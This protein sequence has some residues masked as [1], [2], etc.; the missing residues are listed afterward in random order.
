M[1]LAL[2]TSLVVGLAAAAGSA[3]ANVY[4]N[5]PVAI[6]QGGGALI[7]DTVYVGLGSAGD[8]FFALDLKNANK[9]WT[10]LAT[11][12]GGSLSQ[13]VVAAVD[14]KIYVL[15]GVGTVNGLVTSTNDAYEYDPST[16]K[17]TKLATRSP[18]GLVGGTGFVY[19]DRIYV[20]GGTNLEIFNGFFKDNAAAKT[21]AEKGAVAA[22]YF[23]KRTQDYFFN[24]I[25]FSYQPSTNKWYNDGHLD[26][27]GR[28]GA[29]VA[30]K[31]NEFIVVNGE[32]K[33]GL[34]TDKVNL[35]IIGSDGEVKYKELRDLPPNPGEK[36]QDGVAG[37]YT[38]YIGKYLFVAGGA[39]FPGAHEAYEK[40]NLH[41]HKG[42]AKIY[43]K[44][45]FIYADGKWSYAGD[46]PVGSG[47][48]VALS[49]GN[50]LLI[51]GGE[52]DEGKPL[53]EVY[54]VTYDP[55]T[56]RVTFK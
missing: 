15:G 30:I 51:F 26:F 6:K 29:G 9:G 1:K 28:A 37:A 44:A 24:T 33:P 20:V 35:G 34:R 50:D 17:W 56:K 36:V 39:N 46:L 22:H 53:A 42:L 55:A 4:P 5:L 54:V 10:E 21:D 7:N 14:G 23:D 48:G 11:F 32:I 31:G 16:N 3:F 8:K 47:Y 45:A 25:L 38:G 27:K 52:T 2:K 43:Q 19:K 12:P 18:L 13:P 49:Y 40:G 41:A